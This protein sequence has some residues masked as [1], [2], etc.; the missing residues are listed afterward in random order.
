MKT[1]AG[2]FWCNHCDDPAFGDRCHACGRPA[3]W[4]AGNEPAKPTESTVTLVVP[5]SVA[6]TLFENMR[7][8]IELS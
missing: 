6:K 1:K 4:I 3:A 2:H 8:I 5:D 7:S